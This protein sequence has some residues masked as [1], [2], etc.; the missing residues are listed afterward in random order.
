MCSDCPDCNECDLD[1][2]HLEQLDLLYSVAVLGQNAVN[3]LPSEDRVQ[4]MNELFGAFNF[5][6]LN[7]KVFHGRKGKF[8]LTKI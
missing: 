3:Q 6:H 5:Q 8:N 2:V 4:I 7:Q 1:F